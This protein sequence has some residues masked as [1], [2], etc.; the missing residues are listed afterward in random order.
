MCAWSCLLGWFPVNRNTVSKQEEN[1]LFNDELTHA[2]QSEQS[3]SQ[4]PV[5][6]FYLRYFQE[7]YLRKVSV[8]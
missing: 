3:N 4:N 6:P 5:R 2:L 7:S 8:S 1:P